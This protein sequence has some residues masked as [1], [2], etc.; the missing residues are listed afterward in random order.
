MEAL[1]DAVGLRAL[2]LGPGVVD[3]LDRQIELVLMAL[4]AAAVLGAAVGEHAVQRDR[5]LLEER[6]HPIIQQIGGRD[7]ASC[8]RR[9]WRSRPWR[10]CR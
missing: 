4:G 3:V 5:L 2:G 1:A 9:A 8:G 10:R 6:Q 7:R